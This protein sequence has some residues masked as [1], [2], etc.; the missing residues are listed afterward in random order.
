M[1]QIFPCKSLLEVTSENI[2]KFH[3]V[4]QHCT[5]TKYYRLTNFENNQIK[6]KSSTLLVLEEIETP[7]GCKLQEK[8]T[9]KNN[10]PPPPGTLT[11]PG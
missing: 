6:E 1:F 7:R 11:T 9:T 8:T 3:K 4:I 5:W 10:Q 2:A